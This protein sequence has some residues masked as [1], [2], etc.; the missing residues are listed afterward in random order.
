MAKVFQIRVDLLYVRPPIWRRFLVKPTT[1][2]DSFHEMLQDIMGWYNCH[3]WHFQ[4]GDEYYGLVNP[5]WESDIQDASKVKLSQA[6]LGEGDKIEY[7]YDFGDDWQHTVKLE[8]IVDA[9]K[10]QHY[11]IVVK[12]KRNCPP[13][14]CGGSWGYAEFLEAIQ[15]KKH[16]EHED[17]LEWVGGEFDPEAFDIEYI[18]RELRQY[19]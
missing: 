13:E 2:L 10:G 15:N 1:R 19:K 5:F 6:L 9:E 8:K 16:P 11:P 12:G 7:V 18:N 3:L 4:L 17:L 14:D